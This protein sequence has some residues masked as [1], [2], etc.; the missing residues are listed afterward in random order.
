MPSFWKIA[1]QAERSVP[2]LDCGWWEAPSGDVQFPCQRICP[3]LLERPIIPKCPPLCVDY[4]VGVAVAFFS[5]VLLHSLQILQRCEYSLAP[6]E[7]FD[8]S[9]PD[10]WPRWKRRFEQFRFAS[11]LSEEDNQRQVCTLLY[12]LGEGA[13][14]V[15]S[16]TNISGDERK[17]YSA[18]L[19]KFDD[20]FQ[21]RKN[22]IFERARFNRRDQLDG[23]TADEYISALH[24]SRRVASMAHS[25]PNSSETDWLS[26]IRDLSQ[27]RQL[28]LDSTLTLE[29]ATKAVRQREGCNEPTKFLSP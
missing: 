9:K 7:P 8:F 1:L 19:K 16:S 14:D 13:E 2:S 24:I 29:K 18:V 10:E 5:L 27:S 15:L 6:P 21:I 25:N 26:G 4:N 17:A 23:E 11:G 20:F 28:Q 3:P 22:I 12:C